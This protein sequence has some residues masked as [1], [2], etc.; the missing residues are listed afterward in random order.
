MAPEL[1]EFGELGETELRAF[2]AR[3]AGAMRW[4]M[5]IYL[6]G[7][8]GAGKTTLCR[9]LIRALGH[10]G[11]VKSP[12]YGLMEHYSLGHYSALHLDLYRIGAPGEVEF[13][14]ISDLMDDSTLLLVE[15]PERGA[16]ALIPADIVISLD[17]AEDRRRLNARSMSDLGHSTLQD[18]TDKSSS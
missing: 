12:T 18:I 13:L 3:L 8:L 11:S 15:W 9:A 7:D 2:A 4:P 1:W 10:E 6:E 17:H 5:V 16:G 14:G